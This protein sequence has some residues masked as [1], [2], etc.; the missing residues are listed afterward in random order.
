MNDQY[1]VIQGPTTYYKDI[2]DHYQHFNNNVIISTLNN[3]PTNNISELSKHFRVITTDFNFNP[4]TGNLNCQTINTTNGLME[5]KLRNASGVL[6]IRSDMVI[7]KLDIFL[8]ALLSRQK[9][10]F[11]AWHI[12]NYF[13]DYINY[14]PIND[15]INFW[16]VNIN[17]NDFP[18]RNL[19]NNYSKIVGED[20]NSINIAK[21]HVEFFMEDLINYN[22][23]IMWLSRK[24]N[25]S[26]YHKFNEYLY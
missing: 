20:I 10:T 11:L 3:E 26:E 7:N 22:I 15:M 25:I 18:E 12:H 19:T 5:C 21:K 17:N 13:V 23:D 16:N 9:I 14:G 24:I 1:I 4:G 6:K 8:K 2:I